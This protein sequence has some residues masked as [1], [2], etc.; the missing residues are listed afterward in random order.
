VSPPVPNNPRAAAA[1]AAAVAAARNSP[2]VL[3]AAALKAAGAGAPKTASEL[4]QRVASLRRNPAALLAYVRPLSGAQLAALFKTPPELEL[5]AA[6]LK[7]LRAAL[8]SGQSGGGGGST[9]TTATMDAEAAAWVCDFLCGLTRAT[10]FATIALM[11]GAE[12]AADA[13]AVLGAA[14]DAARAAGDAQALARLAETR[15][16][17]RVAE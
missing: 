14:G 12:E 2:G 10:G 5:V 9:T 17:L 1:A 7:G 15:T 13:R 11:L 8:C 4:G 6:L 16:A 3:G